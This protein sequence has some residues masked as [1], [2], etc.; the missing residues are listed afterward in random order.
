MDR[1]K[2]EVGRVREEKGRREEKR[3]SAKRRSQK[4][5]DPGARKGRKVAKHYVFPMICGSGGPK[6]RLAK[7]AGAEPSGQVRDEKLHAAVVWSTFASETVRS[8]SRLE[9]FWKLSCRKGARRCGAKHISKLKCTKHCETSSTPEPDNVKKSAILRDFL[10]VW[11]WQHQK[12][13]NSARPPSKMASWVQSWR[14]C[15][16][17]FC[18]FFHS[19]CLKYSACHAKLMPGHTKCRTCHA[20]SS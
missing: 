1:W 15:T 10:N 19:T 2:A 6:G 11:G 18:N 16:I 20:K 3:I 7:A 17:A 13:S 5:E 14:P 12:R 4:K 9:H 8:T